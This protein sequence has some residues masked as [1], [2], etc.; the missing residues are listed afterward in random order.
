M[1]NTSSPRSAAARAE[2]RWFRALPTRWMGNDMYGHVNNVTYDSFSDTAVALFL[3][4]NGVLDLATSDRIGLVVETQCRYA[5]PLA[6]P[7][8]LAV[9][10][11]CDRLG[12]TSIRYGIGVFR[13]AKSIAAAEGHFGHVYVDR[14]AQNRAV[15]L[16]ETLPD[17]ATRLP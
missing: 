16:P 8:T 2:Y 5:A 4:E 6:L 17:A 14:A 10:L 1:P 15:P 11:R 9:G 13:N 7:D 12:T 3:L